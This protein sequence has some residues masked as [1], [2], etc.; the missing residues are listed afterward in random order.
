MSKKWKRAFFRHI[1]LIT[2][3]WCIF[4]KLFQRIW[5]QREILHFLIPILN[6]LIKNFFALINTFCKLWLQMRKKR[7][8]KTEN[9]FLWMC[10]RILLCNHHRVCISKLLKSVYPNAHC[11]PRQ[12][13]FALLHRTLHFLPSIC[14]ES[15]QCWTSCRGFFILYIGGPKPPYRL[16]FITN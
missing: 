11:Y 6:F 9:L 13:F 7:L 4:S 12:R 8:K 14:S 10:L 5:N 16:S 1:L 15:I 2:F 3:L